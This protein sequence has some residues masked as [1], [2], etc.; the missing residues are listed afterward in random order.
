MRTLGNLTL[1]VGVSLL[2]AGAAQA[3]QEIELHQVSAEGVGDSVGTVSV[4]D[5]EHGL[6]LTPDLSGLQP[7]MHGFHVHEN[8][9]CEPGE[10]EGEMTAAASAGGHLDPQGSGTHGGP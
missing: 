4:E 3:A 8:A 1:G 10:K 5:S 9:S 2:L 6:L 7:G